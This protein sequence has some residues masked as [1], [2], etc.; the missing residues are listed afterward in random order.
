M[1]SGSL[2][3]RFRERMPF[4]DPKDPDYVRSY[5]MADLDAL[6]ELHGHIGSQAD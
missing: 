5:S 1:V 4:T 6:I 2:P 3:R